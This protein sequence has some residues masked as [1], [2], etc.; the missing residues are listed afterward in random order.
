MRGLDE[1]LEHNQDREMFDLTPRPKPPAPS[2]RS[3]QS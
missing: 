3:G 1:F 2:D